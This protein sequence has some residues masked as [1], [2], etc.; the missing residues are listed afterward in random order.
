MIVWGVSCS[1]HGAVK[2]VYLFFRAHMLEIAWAFIT[3]TRSHVKINIVTY[4]FLNRCIS[5]AIVQNPCEPP[6]P[7]PKQFALEGGLGKNKIK[8]TKFKCIAKKWKNTKF[9]WKQ[10]KPQ[11]HG[12]KSWW[13]IRK[14]LHYVKVEKWGLLWNVAESKTI[15]MAQMVDFLSKPLLKNAQNQPCRGGSPEAT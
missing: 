13:N 2:D 11:D 8:N 12:H 9:G 5:N 4:V 3:E 6:G 15:K 10:I 1:K 7:L 14:T